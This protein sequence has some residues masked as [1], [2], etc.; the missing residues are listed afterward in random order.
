MVFKLNLGVGVGTLTLVTH[1]G[2]CPQ[3]GNTPWLALKDCK[4]ALA[5]KVLEKAA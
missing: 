2:T 1:P 5:V 4:G 3:A